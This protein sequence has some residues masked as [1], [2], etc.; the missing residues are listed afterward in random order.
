MPRGPAPD[1]PER[2]TVCSRPHRIPDTEEE[3]TWQTSEALARQLVEEVIGQGKVELIDELLAD[4]FV[5]HETMPGM[6]EGQD[7]LKALVGMFR[8]RSPT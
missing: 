3:T 4:D 1:A 6:P 7:A 5:E 8:A 2:S